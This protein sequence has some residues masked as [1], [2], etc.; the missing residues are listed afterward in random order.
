MVESR[1]VSK[2]AHARLEGI[3]GQQ[4]T[5]APTVTPP[6]SLTA[7]LATLSSVIVASLYVSGLAVLLL[8]VVHRRCAV[9]R[10]RLQRTTSPSPTNL[11]TAESRRATYAITGVKREASSTPALQVS[12]TTPTI[13]QRSLRASGLKAPC[14]TKL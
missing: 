8:A 13:H 6:S 12:K 11:P 3:S 4:H 1:H 7:S 14:F 2:A 10:A 5:R 9:R